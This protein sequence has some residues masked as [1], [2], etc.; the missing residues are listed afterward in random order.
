MFYIVVGNT[1]LQACSDW[2]GRERWG[3]GKVGMPENRLVPH[4]ATHTLTK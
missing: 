4:P 3:V 2:I 1:E